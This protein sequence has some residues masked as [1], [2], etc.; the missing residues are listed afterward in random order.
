MIY[1]FK[2][3]GINQQDLITVYL[4]VVRPVFEYACPVWHTNLPKYLSDDVE[5]VQKRVM[6]SIY[7]GMSYI[8]ILNLLGLQTLYDRRVYLCTKYFNGIKN[9]KHRLNHLLLDKKSNVYDTR[10]GNVY[11]LPKIRTNRFR[12]SDSMGDLQLSIAFMVK[13]FTLH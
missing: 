1:Q 4:S 10:L 5:M 8:D 7:P 11:P 9:T 3:S 2:R 12:N 6:K 13:R